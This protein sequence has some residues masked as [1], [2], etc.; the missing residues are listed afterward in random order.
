MSRYYQLPNKVNLPIASNN[1]DSISLNKSKTSIFNECEKKFP[2]PIKHRLPNI[3]NSKENTPP[4]RAHYHQKLY[5]PW[6]TV[7]KTT[8]SRPG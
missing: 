3:S 7:V 4:R 2:W 8:V 6:Q 5:K 1:H